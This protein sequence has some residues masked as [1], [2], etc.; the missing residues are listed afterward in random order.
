[1]KKSEARAAMWY[2]EAGYEQDKK[3]F[4]HGYTI[5]A[6]DIINYIM[7]EFCE[8]YLAKALMAKFS[9]TDTDLGWEQDYY[10]TWKDDPDDRG[11]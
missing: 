3:T 2:P 9:I 7:D 8:D 11:L 10:D 1:M 6:A 5:G 4:I